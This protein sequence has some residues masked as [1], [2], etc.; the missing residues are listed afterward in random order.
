VTKRISIPLWKSCLLNLMDKAE[1][2]SSNS[3]SLCW[4]FSIW[5]VAFIKAVCKNNTNKELSYVGFHHWKWCQIFY[6]RPSCWFQFY[7]DSHKRPGGHQ[8]HLQMLIL[9]YHM[10]SLA[11]SG[12]LHS[13]CAVS[14]KVNSVLLHHGQFSR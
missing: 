9:V 8:S 12:I 3:L 5:V 13:L 10:T 6:A 14:S 1:E 2:S 4:M 7:T 11:D